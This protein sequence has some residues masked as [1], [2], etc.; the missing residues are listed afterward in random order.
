MNIPIPKYFSMYN[1]DMREDLE[2]KGWTANSTTYD[3]MATSFGK[4]G[5]CIACGQCEN[6]CP[7][8]LSIIEL[9]KTVSEHFD[10]KPEEENQA[11]KE[12]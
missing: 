4:A 10:H 6:I 1:E 9:M 5:D 11:T 12:E 3:V 8:H 7:Q 2:Q